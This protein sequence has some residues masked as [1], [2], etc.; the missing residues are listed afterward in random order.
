MKLNVSQENLSI[1]DVKI[2]TWNVLYQTL[3]N[4]LKLILFYTATDPGSSFSFASRLID[5][6]LLHAASQDFDQALLQFINII[7]R[8]VL[9]YA[10][11]YTTPNALLALFG[12]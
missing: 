8:R 12:V 6:G 11:L 1:I 4:I 9:V 3:Q 5:N 10:L 2:L 7:H